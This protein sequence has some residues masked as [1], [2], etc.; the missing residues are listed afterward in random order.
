[1]TNA[2]YTLESAF[3]YKRWDK[4]ARQQQDYIE[5]VVKPLFEN[6]DWEAIKQ[7]P[8]LVGKDGETLIKF[9]DDIWHLKEH[10]ASSDYNLSKLTN[11]HFFTYEVRGNQIDIGARLPTQ[12]SLEIKLFAYYLMFMAEKISE[13]LVTVRTFVNP[14]KAL[15]MECSEYG[16]SSLQEVNHETLRQMINLGFVEIQQKT[17]ISLNMLTKAVELP[18]S[19]ENSGFFTTKEFPSLIEREGEQNQVIPLAVYKTLFDQAEAVVNK[20]YDNR[21]EIQDKLRDVQA[22]QRAAKTKIQNA[23]RSGSSSAG[24]YFRPAVEKEVIDRFNEAGIELVDN[25]K[26]GKKW[27]ELIEEIDPSYKSFNIRDRTTPRMTEK[28]YDLFTNEFDWKNLSA[29][30]DTLYEID[31]A[32]R[33][34]MQALSGMRTDELWRIRPEFGLQHATIKG[35]VVPL[36]TTRQSK[37]SMNANTVNDVYVTTEMGA[38]AYRLL[39]DI[40]APLRENF[41]TGKNRFFGGFRGLL[42]TKPADK[43]IDNINKYVKLWL[44]DYELTEEDLSQLDMSNPDRTTN[45]EAGV[46]FKFNPHQLRRSLAFYLIGYELLSYPQLKQQLSHFSVAM[47]RWYARYASSFARMH[48]EMEEERA[49]QKAQI[50]ARIHKKLRN[51]ERL[52]GG[53]VTEITKNMSKQGENEFEEGNEDRTVTVEYWRRRILSGIEHIHAIAP[54]MYCTHSS[55]SMRISIDLSDCVDCGFDIF[56]FATYAES[57]RKEAEIALHLANEL[58]ELNPPT[59]ARQVVQIRSAE[60][61][62]ADMDVPFDPVEIP[63]KWEDMIIHWEAA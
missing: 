49:N 8:V 57:V 31:A 38:K 12:L 47:T 21:A 22:K 7:L 15:A 43:D 11:I 30:K 35:T 26:E 59:V 18:L 13:R 60:K 51:G 9:G 32:C 6:Q 19:F 62:M 61:L 4:F 37:I 45:K 2:A 63:K 1:M 58:D 5:Y 36:L 39:N 41:K 17:I 50:M 34:L 25:F 52:G 42:K 33:F 27:V 23:I 54:N 48:R 28:G 3:N 40:H 29:F 46:T 53:K 10:L 14:L 44:K 55:C 20:Y 56:E 16:L 24:G